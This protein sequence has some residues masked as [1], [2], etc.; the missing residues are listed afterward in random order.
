MRVLLGLRKDVRNGRLVEN[1]SQSFLRSLKELGHQVTTFGLGSTAETLVEA[2]PLSHDCII[3]LDCGRNK[4]G[5]FSWQVPEWG[6][7]DLPPC[8][9]WWIDSHGNPSLHKRLAPYYEHVFFAVYARRDLFEKHV[10]AHW[11]PCATDPKWFGRT[12]FLHV[13]PEFDFGFFG[14]KKGLF[15]ADQMKR[16]CEA[17]GWS[18]DIRQVNGAY[19]HQWPHTGEAMSKCRILFNHGQKHDG[20]NQRVLES[21]AVGRPL[22]NDLDA[23]SGMDLLF[24]D[25]V[26]YIGYTE[27]RLEG[28]MHKA[29]NTN[30]KEMVHIAYAETMFKHTILHRAISIMEVI[31]HA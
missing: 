20:P 7:G 24:E 15:R 1:Y 29:L 28:L 21:M 4:D 26:H 3:E 25:E 18:Y 22:L 9:V 30:H 14:S 19:K 17:H 5:S 12:L 27:D 23:T 16:I 31:E 11:T 6:R 10:S 2:D 8:A 13:E